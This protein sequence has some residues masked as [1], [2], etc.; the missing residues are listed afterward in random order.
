[1]ANTILIKQNILLKNFE[2]G[3]SD[4]SGPFD[5]DDYYDFSDIIVFGPSKVRILT[6]NARVDTWI[7][8]FLGV[9]GFFGGFT[10]QTMVSMNYRFG[11]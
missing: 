9:G 11:I 1:M 3:F 8:P 4:G 5:E 2:M 10:G 7:L 6:L